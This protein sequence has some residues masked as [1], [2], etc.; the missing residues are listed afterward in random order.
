MATI[1]DLSEVA[2][3]N[4]QVRGISSYFLFFCFWLV[5][6][7]FSLLLKPFFSI[8]IFSAV[9]AIAL[10]PIHRRVM[11]V[12]HNPSFSAVVSCVLFV[13]AIVIPLIALIFV[14]KEEI[15]SLYASI[16]TWLQPSVLNAAFQWAPGHILYDLY[17]RLIVDVPLPS[18][19]IA[20]QMIGFIRGA[21]NFLVGQSQVILHGSLRLFF[22]LFVMLFGLF[23]F[24]R[25][26]EVIVAKITHISLLPRQQEVVLV[27]KIRSLV[28]IVFYG[29]LLSAVVQG[30]IGGIGFAIV[31]MQRPLLLG[32]FVAFLSPIPYI[33]TALVWVPTV[34]LL[35][36]AGDYGHAIFL[37]I[38]CATIMSSVDAF[39]KPLFIGQQ[40][41][42]HPLLMFL[43]LFGG[44]AVYGP[45]G[46]ILGP[47]I[48]LLVVTF[49]EMYLASRSNIS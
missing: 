48:A 42:V 22:G 40:T 29:V 28:S 9:S 13:F 21:G 37:A 33:G 25:D 7:Y 35:Y 24:F 14:L 45:S 32:I 15:L 4:L 36:L 11:N 41:N 47:L 26:G 3:K 39:F 20:D 34:V 1:S 43:S 5:L 46:L 8:I 19:N 31:G 23:Y 44:M 38:W 2:D 16:Q 12:I 30:L 10:M 6:F 49:S 27:E 18:I 17:Q